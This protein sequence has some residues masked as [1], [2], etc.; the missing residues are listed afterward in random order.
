[1]TLQSRASK[2]NGFS[3][4]VPV[5]SPYKLHLA[6]ELRGSLGLTELY[7]VVVDLFKTPKRYLCVGLLAEILITWL[8]AACATHVTPPST[9]ILVETGYGG[10]VETGAG[11]KKEELLLARTFKTCHIFS[12]RLFHS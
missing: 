5:L 2:C 1:M 11:R 8:G 3:A 7:S 12:N 4:I 10:C 9:D 6:H